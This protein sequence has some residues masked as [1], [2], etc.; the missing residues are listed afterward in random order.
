MGFDL[1]RFVVWLLICL[2]LAAVIVV[3]CGFG[4]VVRAQL[5]CWLWVW[6]VVS[7]LFVV[8]FDVGGVG[9]DCLTSGVW[10]FG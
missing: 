2:Q 9:V 5:V 7:C 8:G 4:I 6:A 1:V 10:C 3:L